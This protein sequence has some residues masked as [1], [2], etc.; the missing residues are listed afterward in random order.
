MQEATP[1]TSTLLVMVVVLVVGAVV[2]FLSGGG[3]EIDSHMR[4][5]AEKPAS[6]R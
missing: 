3:K 4:D 1:A 2:F 5:D 6:V